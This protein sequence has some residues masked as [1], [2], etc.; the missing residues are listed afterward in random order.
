[1]FEAS[2]T[3]TL[4][5]ITVDTNVADPPAFEFLQ[6]HGTLT[7]SGLLRSGKDVTRAVE[8]DRRL[9]QHRVNPGVGCGAFDTAS[10]HTQ[11]DAAFHRL[12]KGQHE[13]HTKGDILAPTRVINQL[14][15]FATS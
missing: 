9:V 2:H 4:Q 1:V 14:F 8:E 12:H 13:G 11:G 7:E 10:R 6:H 3:R 5:V 15:G